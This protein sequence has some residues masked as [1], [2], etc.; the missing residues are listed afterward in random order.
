MGRQRLYSRLSLS[1]LEG[2]EMSI[3]GVLVTAYC[4][5]FLLLMALLLLLPGL[6]LTVVAWRPELMQVERYIDYAI[7]SSRKVEHVTQTM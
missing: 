3:K 4:A 1:Q 5:P 2:G 7:V 6:L